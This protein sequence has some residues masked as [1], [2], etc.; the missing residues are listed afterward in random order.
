MKRGFLSAAKQQMNAFVGFENH[1]KVFGRE[2]LHSNCI[3]ILPVW[4]FFA[5][6]KK[7]PPPR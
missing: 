7:T 6:Q 3:E 1:G 5:V 4:L 2:P